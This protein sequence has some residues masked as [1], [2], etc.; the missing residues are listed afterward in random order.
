MDKTQTN[1]FRMYLNTQATLDSNTALWSSIPILVSTKNDF[2]ELIQRIADT[3]E[4]TLSNS[5]AVTADKALVLNNLIEKALIPSGILQAYAAITGDTKLLGKVKLTKTDVDRARETDV[6]ALIAPVINEAR[7]QLANLADYGLTEDMIVEL[8]T[9]LDDFKALIGQPR[10][11]RNQA[12]AAMTLLDELFDA[13]NEV[14]KN[15][16]DKLMIRFQFTH[17]EFYSEYERARTIVD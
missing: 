16:L 15:Q 13:A 2:D 9:S 5:K 11:V 14:V 8:E 3:N 6:E 10:T 1:R 17:T 12:F 7:N 4:K